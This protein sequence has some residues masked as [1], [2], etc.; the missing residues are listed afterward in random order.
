MDLITRQ[1]IPTGFYSGRPNGPTTKRF[2]QTHLDPRHQGIMERLPT[3]KGRKPK[4]LRVS[5]PK[6]C[7]VDYSAIVAES[8]LERDARHSAALVAG[9]AAVMK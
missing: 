6:T 4:P 9:Y 5:S 8:D 1:A 3:P 7:D 2:L